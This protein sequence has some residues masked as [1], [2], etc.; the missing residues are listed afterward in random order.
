MVG[1]P[2]EGNVPPADSAATPGSAGDEASRGGRPVRLALVL[3]VAW[4]LAI[5]V[6]RLLLAGGAGWV[7]FAL[8]LPVLLLVLG[9]LWGVGA[10]VVVVSF[11]TAATLAMRALLTTPRLG[12]ALALLVPVLG[13]S[14]SIAARVVLALRAGGSEEQGGRGKEERLGGA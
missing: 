12:W 1:R 10:A 7:V 9:R 5:V 3:V 2:L 8:A 14:V 13:L 4:L 6:A 11:F